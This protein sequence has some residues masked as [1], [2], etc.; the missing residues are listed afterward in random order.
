MVV[1]VGSGTTT[2]GGSGTECG[3]SNSNTSSIL[4][5]LFGSKMTNVLVKEVVIIVA[6]AIAVVVM[7]A[8]VVVQSYSF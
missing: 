3:M 6:M 2:R 8:V 4:G 1:V 7:I 5:S